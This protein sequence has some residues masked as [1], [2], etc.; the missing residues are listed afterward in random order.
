VRTK[1]L[2]C[3]IGVRGVRVYVSDL[4][5]YVCTGVDAA[6]NCCQLEV[7]GSPRYLL[8]PQDSAGTRGRT[9]KSWAWQDIQGSAGSLKKVAR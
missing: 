4:C 9:H 3:V 7:L 2:G 6:R 1:W 8:C 5:L